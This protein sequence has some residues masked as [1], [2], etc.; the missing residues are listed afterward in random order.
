MRWTAE[1]EGRAGRK[2]GDG[3]WYYIPRSSFLG[4]PI[5]TVNVR[6]EHSVPERGDV[7]R[8]WEAGDQEPEGGSE[9]RDKASK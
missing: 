8:G 7:R 1:A 4:L 5:L 3:W 9:L 2:R 6:P